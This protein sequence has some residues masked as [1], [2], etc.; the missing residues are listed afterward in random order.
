MYN[1]NG[2]FD[3]LKNKFRMKFRFFRMKKEKRNQ[4]ASLE[5]RVRI[6]DFEIFLFKANKRQQT[7]HH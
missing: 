5:I 2:T 3:N 1:V 6:N 7:G 4:A